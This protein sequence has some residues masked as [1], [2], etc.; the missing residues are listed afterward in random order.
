MSKIV[1]LSI[2]FVTIWPQSLIWL[3]QGQIWPSKMSKP[4]FFACFVTLTS[5]FDLEK[6]QNLKIQVHSLLRLSNTFNLRYRSI[7]SDDLE[8]WPFQR[9]RSTRVKGTAPKR[10]S[11]LVE[12]YIKLK[13]NFERNSNMPNKITTFT[14]FK[15]KYGLKAKKCKK[16]RQ[17]WPLIWPLMTFK[18][19]GAPS[20][21]VRCHFLTLYTI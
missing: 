7:K 9:P 12:W 10:F 8:K 13:V 5:E 20:R 3:S 6:S 15:V 4:W 18:K 14:F 21:F 11:D 16:K 2:D 19:K 1:Q 17:I